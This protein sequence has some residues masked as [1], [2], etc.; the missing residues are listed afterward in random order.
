MDNQDAIRGQSSINYQ[1]YL[2]TMNQL[3]FTM[4]FKIFNMSIW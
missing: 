2:N 3:E 1:N 4:Y